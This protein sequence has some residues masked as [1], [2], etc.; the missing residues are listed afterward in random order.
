MP[1]LSKPVSSSI[2][3]WL[4]IRQPTFVHY[5]CLMQVR[6]S[7]SNRR[8]TLKRNRRP[9]GRGPRPAD[10]GPAEYCST[11]GR[12]CSAVPRSRLA[13]PGGRKPPQS[14][15][16]AR[17]HRHCYARGRKRACGVQEA[18][19]LKAPFCFLTVAETSAIPRTYYRGLYT[20]ASL[21]LLQDYC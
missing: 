1:R 7:W 8:G 16:L 19:V 21:E 3:T 14:G 5:C 20:R 6:S 13:G 15:H 2:A 9:R 4:T 11:R 18:T 12:A 10:P 17:L